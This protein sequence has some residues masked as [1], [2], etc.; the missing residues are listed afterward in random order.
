MLQ[1]DNAAIA[2]VQATHYESLGRDAT[3]RSKDYAYW[4]VFCNTQNHIRTFVPSQDQ[5]IEWLTLE[6]CLKKAKKGKATGEDGI[7]YNW[8]QIALTDI[9]EEREANQPLNPFARVLL[10]YVN[11][12]KKLRKLP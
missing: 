11:T 5:P 6:H 2:E 1:T 12:C 3:E 10:M 9:G 7:P 4:D 8:W